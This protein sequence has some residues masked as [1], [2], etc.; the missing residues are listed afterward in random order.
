LTRALWAGLPFGTQWSPQPDTVQ[1]QA[2]TYQELES[3]YI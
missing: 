2:P 1:Q 3:H